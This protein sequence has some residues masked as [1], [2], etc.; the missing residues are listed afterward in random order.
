M[1]HGRGKS[2]LSMTMDK[3]MADTCMSHAAALSFYVVL[4]IIPLLFVLVS[5]GSYIV[6]TTG[7]FFAYI[8]SIL[9]HFIPDV[10]PAIIGDVHN[11]LE[12]RNAIGIIGFVFL[13]FS[14]DLAVLEAK[15]SLDVIFK[16]EKRRNPLFIKGKS[17]FVILL[18]GLL[19]SFLFIITPVF[20]VLIKL[21]LPVLSRTLYII[22]TIMS[23]RIF[24]FLMVLLLFSA[25]YSFLPSK[26]IDGEYSMMA[27]AITA[28]LWTITR[29]MFSWY[30][31]HHSN[32]NI[33]Y[34]SLAA[35]V[36]TILW[37]YYT[38]LIFLFSAEFVSSVRERRERQ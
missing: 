6:G 18:S 34:G 32:I 30:L 4:S 38:S 23:S 14:S 25:A 5:I 37:V 9:R 22:A 10:S 27:G 24:A 21:D 1:E 20:G 15:R 33:V 26:K 8:V 3:F 7:S 11:L 16:L 12:K 2:V 19:V 35:I 28:V 17:M 36:V 31:A 29:V 13:L